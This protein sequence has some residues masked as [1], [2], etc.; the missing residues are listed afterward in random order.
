MTHMCVDAV[1]RAAADFGYECAVAHDA[2]AT[3]DLEFGGVTVPAA[4]VQAA[5]MA[6][7]GFAYANVASAEELMAEF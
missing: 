6:G 3:L 5:F 1:T 7:L 4:K 2:C